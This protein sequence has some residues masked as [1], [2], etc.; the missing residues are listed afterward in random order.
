MLGVYFIYRS[1]RQWDSVLYNSVPTYRK[2]VEYSGLFFRIL[3]PTNPH[4]CTGLVPN[5]LN[6]LCRWQDFS[7][8]DKRHHVN[9][10][11][12]YELFLFVKLAD[13]EFFD[14]CI[15]PMLRMRARSETDLMTMI[16]QEDSEGLEHAFSNM[17]VVLNASTLECI[18]AAAVMRHKDILRRIVLE[19]SGSK[20]DR[21]L[22]KWYDQNL[23]PH[24]AEN[25]HNR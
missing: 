23:F 14:A 4:G 20:S 16:L 1:P 8:G 22:E 18:L 9:E 3:V 2:T 5:Q 19:C 11:A 24:S 15:A 12:C 25:E 10:H 13:R 21:Q 7:S 17:H 6:I